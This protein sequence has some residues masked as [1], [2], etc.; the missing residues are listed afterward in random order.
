MEDLTVTNKELVKKHSIA[1]DIWFVMNNFH[2]KFC[3]LWFSKGDYEERPICPHCGC[4][5]R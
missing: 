1:W 3:D 5:L 4:N 2:C